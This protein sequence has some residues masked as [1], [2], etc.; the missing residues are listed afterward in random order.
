MQRS[1]LTRREALGYGLRLLAAAGPAV[2]LATACSQP[3]A[4]AKPAEPAKPA[5]TTAPAAP[6][7]QQAP[8]QKP[9]EAAKPAAAAKPDTANPAMAAQGEM[10]KRGGMLRAVVQNDFVT[11]WPPI[12][13]GPTAMA[14]FDCLVRWRK[15]D[16]G[17]WGPQPGLA[18]SWELSENAAVFKLRRGV[19]F[20]DGSDFNADVVKYNVDLWMKHPKS[21]AK[22]NLRAVNAENPAEVVDDY[23]VKINLT[24]PAGSLL[25]VLSD[26]ARE[27]GI[28]SKVAHQKLGDDG[29]NLQAVGTGPFVFEQFQ[30]GSQLIVNKNPNYWEKGLDGQP[31]PYLDKIH[32]RF[33]PDDS[34]RFVELKSGNA[35]IAQLLRGRDVP[36]MKAD[37]NLNYS[38][39]PQLGRLYRFF[40]NAQKPPFKDNLK[41][42]QAIQYAI[43]RDSMAKAVGGG[44]GAANY[45]D[46]TEGNLGYDPSVP[47]YTFD[48]A[49]AQALIKESGV[50]TPL[51]VRL[52]V[53]TREADLQQ[54]QIL[55]QMLDKIG[56]KIDI[57][58][59]ERVAWGQKVR[60]S[61]DFE[62]ATQQTT[63]PLDPDTI[64]QAWAPDGPAAYVRPNE[65][66]I[67]DCLNEGRTT[68]DVNKRQATYAKCATQMYETAW[69]GHMWIQPYNYLTNKKL[70]ISSPFY[71]EDWREWSMWFS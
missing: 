30:S 37:P 28:F 60:Q 12:T 39:D 41:L 51:P 44:I 1:R 4:P 48:L 62:M 64:S 31:L 32:Y 66:Q 34:V 22:S 63:T 2:L 19:K 55:Q 68:Y 20:H 35:D 11:M 15:G 53:I 16:D 71:S 14:C 69:W 36:A 7:A 40:F 5:A 65:P 26:G 29:M 43:D 21:I 50:T 10:P 13:T 8:A 70:K 56:V 25:S 47:K 18:E 27:T 38:E 24:A 23:T 67:Q 3:Q 54:A 61:N 52:T 58:G 42:R 9:A 17:R 33:V 45:Y 59:L 57:E 46:L 49:K 6:A